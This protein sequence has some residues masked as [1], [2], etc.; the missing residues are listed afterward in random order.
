MRSWWR[1]LTDLVLPAECGGC[2]RP[3]AVL[4]DRCR[5]AL[6]D[7]EPRRVRPAPEPR[8]LPPVHAAAPYADEVRAALLAHKERGALAL[9][10]PLGEAL[11][12]AVRAGLGAPAARPRPGSRDGTGRAASTPVLL[13]PVPSAR[14]AV[15]A[16][17]HDPA[18]RIAYAAAGELRRSG[19]PAAVLAALR[20]RRPVADQ[21][22]LG[23]RQRLANVAGALAVAPGCARLLRR[24]RVVLVDDLMTTGATLAEAA[25]A[26]TAAQGPPGPETEP[27]VMGREASSNLRP[28]FVYLGETWEGSEQ[29]RTPPQA[30]SGADRQPG[31]TVKE[32]RGTRAG[33][34]P[35][36]VCAAVVAASPDAFGIH[37]N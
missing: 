8:G 1:D 16:R 28:A 35:G 25:R 19:V 12:G 9:A 22:G 3:R 5:A 14:R 6:S 11:A 2:G 20:Q 23:S 30:W 13:V 26:V 17:G 27:A 32:A 24:G 4:C 34:T 15:R 7:R 37:R 21:S 36:V 33:G 31:R 18:R 29:R 10:R